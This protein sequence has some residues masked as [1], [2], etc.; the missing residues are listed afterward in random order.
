MILMKWHYNNI[1]Q[2]VIVFYSPFQND[3]TLETWHNWLLSNLGWLLSW[4]GSGNQHQSFKLFKRFQEN[5]AFAYI[6][7]I[8]DLMRCVQKIYSKMHHVLILGHD[9]T[10]LVNPGMLK[11][12][13][14]WIHRERN[15]NFLWNKKI[16]NLCFRW[17]ILRSYCFAAE[18]TFKAF[19]CA[20]RRRLI[21]SLSTKKNIHILNIDFPFSRLYTS[22]KLFKKALWCN[23]A[24]FNGKSS[25]QSHSIKFFAVIFFCA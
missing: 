19:S 25:S 1:C 21:L 24:V 14:T 9:I 10:D 5:I 17:H 8:G 3:E 18:A 20:I 22:S 13:I 15:M 6:W 12:T 2:F 23:H 16:L 7:L 11:N 4:K